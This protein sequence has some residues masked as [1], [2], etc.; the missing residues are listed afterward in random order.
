MHSKRIQPSSYGSRYHCS[1][2]YEPASY[3][4]SKAQLY[5][6][7]IFVL[8]RLSYLYS[9]QDVPRSLIT[10]TVQYLITPLLPLDLILNS[11]GNTN[12]QEY[13]AL[14]VG[15]GVTAPHPDSNPDRKLTFLNLNSTRTL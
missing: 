5:L 7:G 1:I 6:T 15:S 2:R 10:T 3:S 4:T 8:Y 12:T 14:K 11:V 13:G 9:L